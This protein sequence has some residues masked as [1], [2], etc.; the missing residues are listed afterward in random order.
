MRTPS[1]SNEIHKATSNTEQKGETEKQKKT[2]HNHS[3]G[4]Y[5]H[6]WQLYKDHPNRKDIQLTFI[7][8]AVPELQIV[9]SS[10][11]HMEHSQ[12]QKDRMEHSQGHM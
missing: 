10:L 1:G 5:I 6:H 7:E 3:R 9:H 11:A 2:K 4:I 12:G 8:P